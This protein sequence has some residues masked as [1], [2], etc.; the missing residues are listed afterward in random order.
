MMVM[1]IRKP[2]EFMFSV[3]GMI[4]NDRVAFLRKH[5]TK[6]SVNGNTKFLVLEFKSIILV[7]IYKELVRC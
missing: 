5:L 3:F 2:V 1:L 4:A 6:Y 7:M